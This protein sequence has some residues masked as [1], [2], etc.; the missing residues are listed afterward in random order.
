MK[1]GTTLPNRKGPLFFQFNQ[2]LDPRADIHQVFFLENLRNQKVILKLNDLYPIFYSSSD[3][4]DTLK[5]TLQ[6]GY[7]EIDCEL[8][9]IFF[10]MFC[11]QQILRYFEFENY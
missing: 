6:G 1:L 2:F 3:S 9:T 8:C 11:W 4:C 7:K 10:P 5:V